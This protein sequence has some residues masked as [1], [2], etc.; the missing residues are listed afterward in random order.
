MTLQMSGLLTRPVDRR[1]GLKYDFT[2]SAPQAT[3]FAVSRF[4]VPLLAHSGWALFVDCDVVFL[5]DVAELEAFMDPRKAV[6]AVHHYH[7]TDGRTTKMVGHP[8]TQ[9]SRKNWSSV[10]LFN[11]DHP[12]NRRLN[13]SMLNSWPGRDLHAFQWLADSEIGML[14][15]EWNWLVNEQPRPEQPKIAHFTMGGP[16]LSGWAPQ[17]YDELWN[18]EAA[19]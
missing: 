19:S 12:A 6:V 14:P 3:E 9:Y 18:T 4:F 16:W 2:S 11:C 13:L 17:P 7:M 10:M 5:A 15:V 8:Q 1:H